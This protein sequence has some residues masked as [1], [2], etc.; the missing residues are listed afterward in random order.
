VILIMGY[1]VLYF[2][3]PRLQPMLFEAT[4]TGKNIR[5]VLV[6]TFIFLWPISYCKNVSH[7]NGRSFPAAWAK[8]S[9][10]RWGGQCL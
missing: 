2:Q 3:A 8:G 1:G 9:R 6:A 10:W 5:N 7:C 4:L